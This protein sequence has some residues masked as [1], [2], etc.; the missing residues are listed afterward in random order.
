MVPVPD[1]LPRALRTALVE[2]E[3]RA[4][5]RIGPRTSLRLGGVERMR[6]GP[7]LRLSAAVRQ[8]DNA[9]VLGM[10]MRSARKRPLLLP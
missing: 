3:V 2:A 1:C 9:L 6:M 4:S 8:G 5:V 7:D 10:V